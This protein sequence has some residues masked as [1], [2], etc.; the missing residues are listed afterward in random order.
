MATFNARIHFLE[1]QREQ[2]TLRSKDPRHMTDEEL[3]EVITGR[4]P[5][6]AADYPAEECLIGL[7][8]VKK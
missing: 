5:R 4:Y 2:K 8:Q 7:I 6:S 1:V 3:I